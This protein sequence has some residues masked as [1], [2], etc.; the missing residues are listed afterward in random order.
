[1]LTFLGHYVKNIKI[2]KASLVVNFT[3]VLHAAFTCKD[4]KSVKIQS[5]CQYLFA[6]LGSARVNEIDPRVTTTGTLD[7]QNF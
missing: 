7:M 3:N 1:M 5:S 4:P 6:L 2:L